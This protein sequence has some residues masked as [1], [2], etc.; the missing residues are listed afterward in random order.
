MDTDI[1]FLA[2]PVLLEIYTYCE[3]EQTEPDESRLP[4]DRQI[5][6]ANS[7]LKL[8]SDLRDAMHD[9]AEMARAQ[10]DE[11]VCL[12]DYDLGHINRDNI[13]KHYRVVSV[14]VPGD[15]E[16]EN[17]HIFFD[18]NCRWE[19]EHGLRLSMVNGQFVGYSC[20]SGPIGVRQ[21]SRNA[22]QR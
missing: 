8:P 18:A 7:L 5:E 2:K 3:Y 19:D 21:I 12:P 4:S 17:S 14:I 15:C 20:Q 6:I 9:V 10:T 13:G 1:P 16:L 11:E 22:P